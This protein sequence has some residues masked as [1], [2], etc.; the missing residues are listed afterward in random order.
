MTESLSGDRYGY[1]TENLKV[2]RETIAEAAAESGRTPDEIRLMAVTKTVPPA[3]INYAIEHGGITLI[4]ENK[5]QE[6]LEKR[7]FLSLQDVE[8]H[9]IGHLQTNKV[10]KIIPGVSM[11]QS[12]DSVH[13]AQEIAR[14]SL[15]SGITTDILIE[16]NIGKEESK[17]GFD[18]EKAIDGLLEIAAF[19]GIR[20]RGL[21]SVPPVCTD[22][23]IL[24]KYFEN[25]Y[26]I[27]VDIGAKKGDNNKD[28]IVMD[29]LSMGMSGDYAL[30]VKCGSN[31]VRIGSGIFGARQY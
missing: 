20:V 22:L 21:M 4:G 1:I 8:T 13:L 27:F 25:M 3:G 5:V 26:R 10:K 17:T 29:I 28:S 23:A 2:I 16:I 18:R 24:I 11:I 19:K 6:L 12:V 9:M 15:V 7:P 31:L 14:V 30:A